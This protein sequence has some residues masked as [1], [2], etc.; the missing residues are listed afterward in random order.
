MIITRRILMR[1]Q[2][3]SGNLFGQM[4]LGRPRFG[5]IYGSREQTDAAHPPHYFSFRLLKR[6][7]LRLSTRRSTRSPQSFTQHSTFSFQ[8]YFFVR[9]PAAREATR[10]T[11]S[12][13]SRSR[14]MPK[15]TRSRRLLSVFSGDSCGKSALLSRRLSPTQPSPERKKGG[16]ETH[17]Y[18]G[19]RFSGTGRAPLPAQRGCPTS[20]RDGCAPATAPSAPRSAR[21]SPPAV[22]LCC[23]CRRPVRTAPAAPRA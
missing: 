17:P 16:F 13:M 5:F 6:L 7:Y 12:V 8:H 20:R 9:S 3:K 11:R 10:A 2:A 19:V 14:R 15:N 4:S 18:N 22:R 21:P 1:R 23:A